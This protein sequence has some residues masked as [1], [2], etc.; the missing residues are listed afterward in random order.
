MAK[1]L[2][3][4]DEESI[5]NLLDTLLRRKGYDVVLAESGPKGLDL[6]RRERPDVIVL[7][8]KMPEMT[9]L[10]VLQQIRSLDPKKPVIILTGA[11]TAEAE[12]QVRALGVT[13]FIEKEFSLHRLGDAL[14]RFLNNPDHST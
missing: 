3:I 4:D 8:L 13:E 12:Q 9:G 10:E 5:R 6:F 2:V 1:L 7:D 11:G 14:K